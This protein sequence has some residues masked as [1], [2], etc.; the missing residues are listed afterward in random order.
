MATMARSTGRWL[1][2]LHRE[3]SPGLH[4][5]RIS[6]GKTGNGNVGGINHLGTLMRLR[7][8]TVTGNSGPGGIGGGG[9]AALGTLDAERCTI[10][11]NQGSGSGS[12]GAVFAAGTATV[13][14]CLVEFHEGGLGG[15][16]E[17]DV[18]FTLAGKTIVQRN[19][20]GD[21]GIF[22]I[23]FGVVHL[24]GAQ[25]CANEASESPQSRIVDD[26]RGSRQEVCPP[27]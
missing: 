18:D 2:R 13:T 16:I 24:E 4:R 10:S 11:H 5:L 7:D 12:V 6:K 8:C 1:M 15:G 22:N 25:V 9:I 21:G 3:E 20:A 17:A 27:E 26:P 14:D 23:S 19:T